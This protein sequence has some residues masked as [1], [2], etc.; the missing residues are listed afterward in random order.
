MLDDVTQAVLEHEEV[1]KYLRGDYGEAGTEARA[2][3][4]G[5]LDELRTTQRYPFYR[6]LQ[7]PLYPILRKIERIPENLQHVLTSTRSHRIVYASNHKSHTDSIVELLVLDD[8]GVRPPL[9]TAGINMFGGPLGLLHRHVTGAIPIRRNLKDP[10]YL[11]TLKAY[12]AEVLKKHD[13]FI[14]PEGGRSYSGE[15]KPAKTG[16]FRAAL[17]AGRRDLVIIPA[18]IAYDLVLEDHVLARQRVKRRQR[19]FGRE[20]A[21]M[22]R[23]AVGYRSRAFVTF[24]APIPVGD[25]DPQSGSEILELARVVRARIGELYKVLPTAVLAASMRPSIAKRD[26]EDRIDRLIEELAARRANLGVTSGRQAI[27]EAAEPLETRGI[28]VL[29]RGRFRVRDRSVLRYYAR[30]IDHLLV[31]PGRTH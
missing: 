21:E 12:V 26:L 31:T 8:N 24:G 17:T 16:L 30:S 10:A 20:L 13:L 27:E 9:I 1:L 6:A 15:L 11:I 29:E 3:I 2:R 25:R 23:Y 4:C 19:P 7:H 5:Y 14:Y 22:V 18:A 28:I